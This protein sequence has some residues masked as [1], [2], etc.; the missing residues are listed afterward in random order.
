MDPTFQLCHLY[1]SFQ[2]S[3]RS[4]ASISWYEEGHKREGHK[5]EATQGVNLEKW[6]GTGPFLDYSSVVLAN[7]DLSGTIGHGSYLA[8]QVLGPL[9]YCNIGGT[10]GGWVDYIQWRAPEAYGFLIASRE[11][12]F[13]PKL[14]FD[15]FTIYY[16]E[17]NTGEITTNAIS[18][19]N[20]VRGNSVLGVDVVVSQVPGR[21]SLI[22]TLLCLKKRGNCIITYSDPELLYVMSLAFDKVTLFRPLADSTHSYMIGKGLKDNWNGTKTYPEIVRILQA[23]SQL[24]PTPSFLSWLNSLSIPSLD[25]SLD[26]LLL[27]RAK[28][29]WNIPDTTPPLTGMTFTY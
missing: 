6:I 12:D 4:Q 15:R 24:T 11:E 16:G 14:D 27:Y 17:D 5:R 18:F 9:I 7:L 28:A 23:E 20:Y 13:S 25:R 8:R 19:A 21:E 22:S 3:R 29:I 2:D 1:D 10:P 26:D